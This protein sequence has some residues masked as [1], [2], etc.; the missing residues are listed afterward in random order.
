MK[1]ISAVVAFAF[2][3]LCLNAW[4]ADEPVSFSGTWVLD[5]AKSDPF[6][7]PLLNLGTPVNAESPGGMR[8]GAPGG[9]MPGGG[10]RGGIPG[11]GM[12]GGFPGGGRGTGREG[13]GAPTFQNP[14]I[15][16]IQQAGDEIQIS[17][18]TKNSDGKE[19]PLL[20]ERHKLDGQEAVEMLT[21][22]NSANQV[23]R[24]IKAT[25]KKKRFQIVLKTFY[26][27]GTSEIKREYSLSND[28]KILRLDISTSRVTFQTLQK[29]IYDK[30][31]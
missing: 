25:L 2:S 30:Q 12:P 17:S 18:T 3:C 20:M 9:A 15:L 14:A 1:R 28:G 19:I 4:A 31:E 21:V 8:G 5:S 23:K 24:T 6:P 7:Q 29:L 10:M 11:G 22:P 27:Q 13:G 26:P 16:T